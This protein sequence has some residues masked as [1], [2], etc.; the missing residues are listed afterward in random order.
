MKKIIFASLVCLLFAG[1]AMKNSPK[2]ISEDYIKA[3]EE[4]DFRRAKAYIYVP[5]STKSYISTK[6]IDAKVQQDF[7]ELQKELE[8]IGGVEEFKIVKN[9]QISETIRELQIECKGKNGQFV[10]KIFYTIN[11][12]GT[13]KLIQA[14]K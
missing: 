9:T 10:D 14:V 3:L 2:Y 6:D 1:C 5:T 4:K 13:W 11:I 7:D 12:D 8:N